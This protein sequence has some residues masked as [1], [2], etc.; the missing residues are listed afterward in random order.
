MLMNKSM[1]I[2][3]VA[4]A[5][6][7]TAGG[8]I[9]GYKILGPD[10]AQVTRVEPVMETVRT[11]RLDC[12]DVEVTRP[13]P[14][15]DEKRIAG[16]AIGAVVGGIIGSQVGSGDGR[17]VA[18][19]AGAAGGGYAGSKVQKGMQDRNTITTIE[20]DC[21]TVYD[22]SQRLAGYDVTYRFKGQEA[23]VRMDHDPGSRIAVRDGL[24]VLS[25]S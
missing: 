5:V 25:A 20:K 12:R 6:V 11:P 22:Q 8:A 13:A 7:V 16:A 17:K 19:A 4:G 9:A 24:P 21:K 18:T 23:T 10:Y 2:G 1:L 14:V 15:K 3:L